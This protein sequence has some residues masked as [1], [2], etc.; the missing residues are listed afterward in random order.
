MVYNSINFFLLAVAWAK[1]RFYLHLRILRNTELD[2]QTQSWP[3]IALIVPA[4]NEEP[5][6]LEN[7]RSLCRLHY[8]HLEIIIVNDGSADQTV[9][10][11]IETFEFR[12]RDTSYHAIVPTA[13]LLG[14]YEAPPPQGAQVERL[15][16]I[17]KENAGKADAL[18]A[19][20]NAAQAGYVCCMDADSIINEDTLLQVMGPIVRDP[21]GILACGGQIGIANGCVIEQGRVVKTVL[22]KNWL[23]LFQV[24]EYMRSFTAGRTG[25][26]ELNS[27]LILSGVFALLRRDIL[28]NMGGFLTRR[29]TAKIAQEYCGGQETVCEDME[30]IVRLRRYIIEKKLKGKILFLPYPITW[31]QAPTTIPDFGK[32]RNRWF[33]GLSQVLW[34]HKKM[35][36]NPA[37]KEVGLFAMPYQFL[38]EFIGPLLELSGYLLL[39]L[40]YWTGILKTETFFLFFCVSIIYGSMLTVFAV[41]LGLWSEGRTARS[42]HALFQYEGAG[43]ALKL[44]LLAALSMLGYRQ[45]QLAFQAQGFIDFLKGKQ[46]WKK[47]ER[48]KF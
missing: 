12:R 24:V 19:G 14:F 22:P 31:S 5:T 27:L 2:P 26:A 15:V 13:R 48:T 32:Q 8:P 44:L 6:I 38:F 10:R 16:L 43:P 9:M 46:E 45:L 21:E 20:I 17:D 3:K 4:F 33:R 18:N 34:M 7:I 11:L 30:I 1:V 35:L 47:F 23:A 42:G 25:L 39:P 40:F 28:L 37:Y 41:M 36:F 29:L